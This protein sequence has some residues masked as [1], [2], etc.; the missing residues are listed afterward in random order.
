M[1]HLCKAK[2]VSL[3]SWSLQAD[4]ARRHVQVFCLPSAAA[5]RYLTVRWNVVGLSFTTC[6]KRSH[7]AKASQKLHAP[8]VERYHHQSR[9]LATRA[10]LALQSAL[11]VSFKK[12][13]A[14]LLYPKFR[15][16]RRS[17]FRRNLQCCRLTLAY[18]LWTQGGILRNS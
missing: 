9:C 2:L 16:I 13:A 12:K 3:V 15:T 11:G 14:V 17:L 10:M 7:R 8:D 6:K 18:C 4:E 1:H 5:F